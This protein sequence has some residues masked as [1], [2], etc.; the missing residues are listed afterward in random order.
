MDQI[1]TNSVVG[2]VRAHRVTDEI[3]TPTTELNPNL[4]LYQWGEI[5]G[6]LLTSGDA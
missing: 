5:V 6:M 2:R 1:G 4:V 3:W